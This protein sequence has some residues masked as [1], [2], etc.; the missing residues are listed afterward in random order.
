MTTK[1]LLDKEALARRLGE[2]RI[3]QPD[4]TRRLATLPLTHGYFYWLLL[5]P[6]CDP[7][8]QRLGETYRVSWDFLSAQFVFWSHK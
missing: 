6:M 5:R 4:E 8:T 3:W 2:R 7:V 1:A